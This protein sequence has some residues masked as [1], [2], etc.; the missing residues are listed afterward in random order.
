ML[1]WGDEAGPRAHILGNLDLALADS[2]SSDARASIHATKS[3]IVYS[4]II[5]IA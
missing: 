1:G 3:F 5:T 4:L 2:G